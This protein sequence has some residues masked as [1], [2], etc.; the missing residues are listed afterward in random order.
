MAL[1]LFLFLLGN[2]RLST[3]IY[4]DIHLLLS[5]LHIEGLLPF[6]V[7]RCHY[8]EWESLILSLSQAMGI[9]RYKDLHI[10]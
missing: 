8:R 3:A 7:H 2:G 9:F 6:G 10:H 1:I 5:S 4:A